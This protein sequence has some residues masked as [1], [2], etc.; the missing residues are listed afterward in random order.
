MEQEKKEQKNKD[1]RRSLL[2]FGILM[3]VIIG[4]MFSFRRLMPDYLMEQGKKYL[5]V[6]NYA[7][8]L[9]MFDLAENSM[10]N[11]NEPYY[12]QVLAL[13]KL[14]I[15]Y[16]NLERLYD[17]T[18][19]D[20]CEKASNAARQVLNNLREQLIKT[21]GP[22]YIDN[23][24]YDN[25]LIRFNNKEP[26]TYAIVTDDSIPSNY[27][28]AVNNAILEWEKASNGQILFKQIEDSNKAKIVISFHSATIAIYD[29]MKELR[30]RSGVSAPVFDG[31]KL[32]YVDIRLRKIDG[33]GQP[34]T[35][36]QIYVSARH[37]IGHALGLW[38]HSGNN[39][40]VMSYDQE[41]FDNKNINVNISMRDMN[42]LAFVYKMYPDIIDKPI[43]ADEKRT[44]F[45]NDFIT[46]Y[47][48]ENYDK[49]I[50]TILNAI[51][52]DEK[53]I[54][55]WV[56]IAINCG[57]KKLYERSNFILEKLIP[58]LTFDKDNRQVVYYNMAANYYALC[59]YQEA[60]KYL[61]F[62]SALKSDKDTE[63]L[64]A[65][66]DFKLQKY[67]IA[68]RELT[69]LNAQYPD[70]IDVAINLAK[71]FRTEGNTRDEKFV[72]DELIRNNP[73]AARDRRVE[74]YKKL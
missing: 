32:K 3:L 52:D 25:V 19:M 67:D 24:L 15:T 38:G 36:D 46:M 16:D 55:D 45:F 33:G 4:T 64:R 12:Y 69:K 30:V 8:A 48:G 11:S 53:K 35:K 66:I 6:K 71:L 49:E 17:I 68:Q 41:F 37:Q 65:F 5:E 23:V 56:D 59:M 57:Y 1:L 20:N 44:L 62:A 72:I 13:T 18:Q 50:S 42:T 60:D 26:I 21:A 43:S 7:K 61:T 47:P 2:V 29:I 34:A 14:P 63:I 40:D 31:K 27:L 9:E 74:N 22:N 39:N 51:K 54:I 10:P 70:N 28:E 58:M 73:N